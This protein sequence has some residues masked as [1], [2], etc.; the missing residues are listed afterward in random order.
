MNTKINKALF[1]TI[2]VAFLISLVFA[3]SATAAEGLKITAAKVEGGAGSQVIVNV[4]AEKAAGSEGGQFTLTFDQSLVKPVLIEPGDLVLSAENSLHMANL[5]YAPG[6]L[7]FM[8]VT[9]NADTKDSGVICRVTFD[10]LKAGTTE[11]GFKDLIIVADTGDAASS[12]ASQIKVNPPT[13]G[14]GPVTDPDQET[15][16]GE[17][18]PEPGEDDS[19]EE[20]IGEDDEEGETDIVAERT[21]INPILVVI[22]IAVIITLGVIYYLL[23]RTGNKGQQKK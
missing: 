14:G 7:I 22:P 4:T 8:W 3:G 10:L 23:K 21:G 6:E 13:P 16:P 17:D 15:E 5:D 9:A 18:D 1:I 20:V 12:T 2:I 11:V 19:A